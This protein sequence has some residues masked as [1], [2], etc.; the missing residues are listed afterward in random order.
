MKFVIN[1]KFL[2]RML[3]GQE[4]FAYEL[5]SELDRIVPA[6]FVEI[7]APKS[8]KKLPEYKNIKIKIYGDMTPILWEQTAYPYYLWKHGYVGINLCTTCPVIKPD[9]TVIHDICQV[10]NK[11][12]IH[13][14]YAVLSYVYYAFMRRSVL[15]FSRTILTVSNFSKKEI[16]DHYHI[17]LNRIKVLGNGWQHINRIRNDDSI[18][19]K[20]PQLKIKEYFLAASSLTPQKNF[21]WVREVAKRNPDMQFVI[22][23]KKVGLTSKD[24]GET[25]ENEKNIFYVGYVSDEELK[26]LMKN[27][28][29]FIHPAIYEGFGIPPLEALSQGVKV[30][31]SDRASL[32]EIFRKSAYYI[33][34]YDYNV[35]LNQLLQQDVMPPNDILKYYSWSRFANKL[36]NLLLSYDK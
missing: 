2:T 27:C 7:V 6:D 23:G 16:S 8:V 33:D 4:R 14:F 13:N 15:F 17:S 20:Y 18:L 29:A 28:R 24:D 26:C 11:K 31:V 3:S 9:I 32:P 10:M 34:P 12:F 35:D 21:K 30:I 5:I 22:S 36:Y 25:G 1:G 19:K